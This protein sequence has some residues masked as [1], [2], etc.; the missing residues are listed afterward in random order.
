MSKWCWN[1]NR[2]LISRH[3][4]R[5][6]HTS[7]IC[8]PCIGQH[9]SE[10]ETKSALSPL[11]SN[12]QSANNRTSNINRTLT[13]NCSVHNTECTSTNKIARFHIAQSHAHRTIFIWCKEE[14]KRL[15]N[16]D[17]GNWNSK[18]M[19]IHRLILCIVINCH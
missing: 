11:H 7:H 1:R 5:S 17:F 16:Y 13:L 15:K 14:M 4:Q 9:S 12:S 19:T 6:S 10:L 3:G 2:H 8:M 18:N